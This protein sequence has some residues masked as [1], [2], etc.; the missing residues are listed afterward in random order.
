M[1]KNPTLTLDALAE[2]LGT[3]RSYLSIVINSRMQKG[4]TEYVNFYRVE[5]AKKLLRDTDNKVSYISAESGFGS[6]QT[7]YSI[8]KN[9]VQL[10][11]TEYRK[12]QKK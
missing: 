2:E 3:N 5:E 6:P 7:F 4:F 1:F 12:T 9:V 11:P 8:F 10:T